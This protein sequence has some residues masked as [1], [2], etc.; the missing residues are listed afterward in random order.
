MIKDFNRELESIKKNQVDI[1][2]LINVVSEIK[3]TLNEIFPYLLI[4]TYWPQSLEFPIL[5]V[6]GHV[7]LPGTTRI[8]S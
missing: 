2:E 5:P 7:A 6:H 4:N 8:S 3:N 1:L